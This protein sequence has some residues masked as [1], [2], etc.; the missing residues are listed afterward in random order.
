MPSSFSDLINN[1]DDSTENENTSPV[2]AP[3]DDESWVRSDRYN[4][5]TDYID[6]LA[7]STIDNKT[8][9]VNTGQINLTQEQNAQYISFVMPR[10]QDGIDLMRMTIRVHYVNSAGNEWTSD[11]VNV[12]Y[13]DTR[14]KFH[15]LV[16]EYVTALQGVL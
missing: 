5:V 15:W 10:F 12:T 7:V 8:I 16:D 4:W 11:V 13:S 2:T 9:T 1:T 14:I 6:D 3:E